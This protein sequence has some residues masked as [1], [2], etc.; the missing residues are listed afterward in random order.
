M[1][2]VRIFVCFLATV[3]LLAAPLPKQIFSALNTAIAEEK[4]ETANTELRV[5]IK[6]NGKSGADYF[7]ESNRY[8]SYNEYLAG[9]E[10]KANSNYQK[11]ELEKLENTLNGICDIKFEYT[12][13]ALTLGIGAYVYKN[14]I[15]KI[16]ALSQVEGVYISGETYADESDNEDSLVTAS[17]T[18][19]QITN[20]LS[21]NGI[22]DIDGNY[23][24]AGTLIAVID[25]G[26]TANHDAFS[27]M[28]ENGKY[29]GSSYLESLIPSLNANINNEK[30][31]ASKLYKNQK[32]V[33]GFDYAMHDADPSVGN[34]NDFHGDHVAGIAA[35]NNGKDFFG[36]APDAQLAVFKVF[37]DSGKA[38]SNDVVA[39]LEDAV[40]IGADVVNISLG[41]AA[42]FSEEFGYENYFENASEI[43]TNV[44]ISAGNSYISAADYRSGG[45]L[46]SNPDYGTISS[47][48][49]YRSTMSVANFN[50]EG[51]FNS[52]SS[53]GPGD[54]LTLKPD[55]ASMGENVLSA[56]TTGYQELSGTSMSA[57]NISGGIAVLKQALKQRYPD[58]SAQEIY[59]M[60]NNL[61]MSTA[62]VQLDDNGTAYSP[63]VQGAGFADFESAI[64]SPSYLYV[65]NSAYPKL[66]LKDDPQKTGD[67]TLTF[68]ICNTS[69]AAQT[70]SAQ[71][72]VLAPGINGKLISNYDVSVDA[73]IAYESGFTQNTVTVPAGTVKTLTV[74]ITLTDDGRA[75]AEKFANGIY[76]EGY[77]SLGSESGDLSIPFLAFYGDWN[78]APIFDFTG[79]NN[80]QYE[81]AKSVLGL[82]INSNVTQKL[83]GL[84]YGTSSLDIHLD[85]NQQQMLI[86]NPDFNA[87]NYGDYS[88]VIQN[89][90]LKSILNFTTG[91]LRNA[92]K[93][94]FEIVDADMGDVVC[95][96]ADLGE[97]LQSEL[98]YRRKNLLKTDPLVLPI[99][100]TPYTVGKKG[101]VMA[102]NSKY[103]LKISAAL[104]Y[105]D[106]T[107]TIEIPFYID[108]ENPQLLNYSV[109]VKNGKTTLNLSMYDNHYIAGVNFY[110][111]NGSSISPLINEFTPVYAANIMQTTT[112]IKDITEA[113]AKLE[114][115][116]KNKMYA[117]IIDF[118]GNE[119]FAEIDLTGENSDSRN[120]AS[121]SE[122]A[123]STETETAE[124]NLFLIDGASYRKTANGNLELISCK[125]DAETFSVADNTVRIASGAFDSTSL[126]KI[127]LPVSLKRLSASAFENCKNLTELYFKGDAPVVDY[128]Y[129]RLSAT[130]PYRLT[131]ET[132]TFK[133]I[134]GAEG[135]NS[136]L[137]KSYYIATGTDLILT[138]NTNGGEEIS[139]MT[140]SKNSSV[141]LPEP[142]KAGF[143]F[144]DW[145]IDEDLTQKA[146]SA[147]IITENTTVY[148]KWT[149]LYMIQTQSEIEIESGIVSGY[150]N[151]NDIITLD[152]FNTTL[153]GGNYYFFGGWTDG[154]S[155]YSGGKTYTVSKDA[156]L[157]AIWTQAIG[158]LSFSV[159][160]KIIL[161]SPV[162]NIQNVSLPDP[163]KIE[164]YVFEGWYT[165]S[166]LS[167]PFVT[168]DY[169]GGTL[170]LYAK[171]S[172]I[173]GNNMTIITIG[174]SSVTALALVVMIII[175]V[176]KRKNKK[177]ADTQK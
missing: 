146:D 11:T 136:Y 37:T 16:T 7:A 131:D 172:K 125:T 54:D 87:L 74:E 91:Q 139:D 33:Y 97:V 177:I 55:I 25:T 111:Q 120:S 50:R 113:A 44:I 116:G 8:G 170:T 166:S 73:D 65:E 63:R 124:E 142:Q 148:A 68:C 135:F 82:G 84:P 127:I 49:C 126:K 100:F 165:D 175:F 173:G 2:K 20:L 119:T 66:E 151:L 114:Q 1:K 61:V 163:D 80:N 99:D 105:M 52:L 160:S 53:W 58:D 149:K 24:G 57:P 46:L 132:I 169:T 144:E 77:V 21:D 117:H 140:V 6:L 10:G 47:M 94:S 81:I 122:I 51:N 13:T 106:K 164:G 107:Q 168:A 41:V 118:A 138:F 29:T 90:R 39:A 31:S 26:I 69:G 59:R 96:D 171:F 98:V 143:K 38:N 109:D 121:D 18:D 3:L 130:N 12:Y 128:C 147:L 28:P 45:A 110:F 32:I 174:I 43:G 5:L 22:Y 35:G 108:F 42:G 86:N 71:T 64:D 60:A 133:Y 129:D 167:T 154:E 134:N 176:I 150:Y 104:D 23:S 95:S 34:V 152:M 88:Y 112:T 145:Y 102:N 156:T 101:D 92:K 72:L 159:D 137:W 14:D 115:A 85:A 79:L 17:E 153:Y 89:Q 162:E 155:V 30:P 123:L 56:N 62:K 158:V 83:G 76:I 67:Y 4:T 40:T 78:A 103:I 141:N 15:P 157:T 75:Y 19:S 161:T 70:Y 48:S 93:I 9:T 36:A 27:A